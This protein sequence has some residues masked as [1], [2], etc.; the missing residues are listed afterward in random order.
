MYPYVIMIPGGGPHLLEQEVPKYLQNGK[1]PHPFT[2]IL[3]FLVWSRIKWYIYELVG[4]TFLE[5][6]VL[7]YRNDWYPHTSAAIYNLCQG[8]PRQ[9]HI[10]VAPL[11]LSSRVYSSFN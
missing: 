1:D 8:S 4:L 5:Q 11:P 6:V 3:L 7:E 9:T 10:T 2:L